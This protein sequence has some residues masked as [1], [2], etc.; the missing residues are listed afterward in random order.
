MNIAVRKF[1][2]RNILKGLS[3]LSLNHKDKELQNECRNDERDWAI[4]TLSKSLL[5]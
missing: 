2:E 4:F 5:W 1:A 3:S